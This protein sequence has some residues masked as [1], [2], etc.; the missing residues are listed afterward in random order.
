MDTEEEAVQGKCALGPPS[1]RIP[2]GSVHWAPHPIPGGSVHGAPI[3]SHPIPGGSVHWAPHPIPGGTV[4]G[5]P[6]PS[7]G[8][9]CTGPPIPSLRPLCGAQGAPLATPPACWRDGVCAKS[10]PSEN[11]STFDG[12][13]SCLHQCMNKEAGS[14]PGQGGE[15][16]RL[17]A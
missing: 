9:V 3:P 12:Q 8:E 2:G 16:L 6:I 7:Q 14:G 4:H 17:S 15:S 11:P 1:H 5:A 10:G 13:K